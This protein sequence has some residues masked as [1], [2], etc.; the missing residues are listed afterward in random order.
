M[1]ALL[2]DEY[3]WAAGYNNAAGLVLVSTTIPSTDVAFNAGEVVLALPN[4]NPGIAST[5]ECTFIRKA[6]CIPP[7]IGFRAT[8]YFNGAGTRG[9]R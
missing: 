3:K 8:K 6:I 7:G 9:P 2:T 1:T 5:T 4:Y